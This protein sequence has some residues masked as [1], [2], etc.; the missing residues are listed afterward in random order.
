MIEN[1]PETKMILRGSITLSL[2]KSLYDFG[3]NVRKNEFR[4]DILPL[5]S[6][7]WPLDDHRHGNSISFG[8]YADYADN[9]EK[10]YLAACCGRVFIIAP[11]ASDYAGF[12]NGVFT[13]LLN[14]D[15]VAILKPISDLVLTDNDEVLKF[16]AW[17][18]GALHD[19]L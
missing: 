19:R 14:N 1:T 6:R 4:Q 7:Q 2:L 3:E 10:C 9:L 17:R 18:I 11:H 12:E 13:S 15:S 5:M 16:T 8:I